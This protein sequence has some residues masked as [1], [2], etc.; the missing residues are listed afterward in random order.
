MSDNSPDDL[1]GWQ[2]VE[3]SKRPGNDRW[4]PKPKA[5]EQTPEQKAAAFDRAVR[6]HKAHIA[7]HGWI[8]TPGGKFWVQGRRPPGAP[9]WT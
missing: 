9:G 8:M 5:P 3:R 4:G 7:E 1:S 6:E 2:P